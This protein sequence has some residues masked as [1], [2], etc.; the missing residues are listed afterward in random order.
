[1]ILIMLV[2]L[3]TTRVVLNILGES[4]YGIY[5]IVGSVVVSMIFIQHSLMSATQRFLS[6]EMGL[7]ENGD[8][9]KVFS[10]S[11]N[12]HLKFII[13]IFVLLESIGLWFLNY[14]LDIPSDRMFA[15]NIVY[16]F[17]ILTFCLNMVRIPYNAIIISYENMNIYAAVSIIEANFQ[18]L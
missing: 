13:I 15:A 17:S 16:Q 14:I 11:L 1:M 8:V 6:Y 10:S 9:A 18:L 5:N 4:D 12:L 3:Y 7:K 2:S